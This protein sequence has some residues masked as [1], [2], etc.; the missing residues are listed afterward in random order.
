[1]EYGTTVSYGQ[2]TTLDSSF[3]A[4][5]SVTLSGLSL[6]TQYHYRVIS[7]DTNDN[8]G[9]GSD[10]TFTTG[11]VAVGTKV[12]PNPA[13]LSIGTPIRFKFGESAGGE[14]KIYALNGILVKSL[15]AASGEVT[16]DL[17]NQ[18]GEKVAKGIYLYK[19]TSASGDSIIGKIGVTK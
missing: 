5:H 15:T 6:E 19:I 10:G 14:V 3:I 12:Y 16:W 8:T 2:S 17:A 18:D 4:S 7:K 11:L 13:S 9:T 1:V